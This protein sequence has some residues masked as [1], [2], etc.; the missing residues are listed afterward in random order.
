MTADRTVQ[1]EFSQHSRQ[2]LQTKGSLHCSCLDHSQSRAGVYW[3]LGMQGCDVS[4]TERAVKEMKTDCEIMTVQTSPH[5]RYT[6]FCSYC[7]CYLTLNY[8]HSR[9]KRETREHNTGI[10]SHSWLTRSRD[11][12]KRDTNS[13]TSRLAICI[14]KFILYELW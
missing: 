1:L 13:G 7:V 4:S 14:T 8:C 11:N 12:R 6:S 3:E 2:S 10:P 5:P 9:T